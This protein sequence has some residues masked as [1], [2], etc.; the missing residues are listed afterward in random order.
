[1]L[2]IGCFQSSNIQDAAFMGTG[3][4]DV[5]ILKCWNRCKNC[6]FF[7]FVFYIWPSFKCYSAWQPA[8]IHIRFFQKTSKTSPDVSFLTHFTVV[9]TKSS[10]GKMKEDGEETHCWWPGLSVAKWP[11][12][13]HFANERLPSLFKLLLQ[14]LELNWTTSSSHF[15]SQKQFWASCSLYPNKLLKVSFCFL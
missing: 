4:A 13:G 11:K 10:E 8:I 2:N 6:L 14:S 5:I 15:Q 9:W 1:M 3:R 7:C 12:W